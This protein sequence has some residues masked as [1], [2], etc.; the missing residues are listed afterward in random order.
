MSNNSTVPVILLLELDL[1][2]GDALPDLSGVDARGRGCQSGQMIVDN[3]LDKLFPVLAGNIS[4][5]QEKKYL[6]GF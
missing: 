4:F 1:F 5:R 3:Q 6:V 2:G